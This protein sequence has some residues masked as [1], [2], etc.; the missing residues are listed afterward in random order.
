MYGNKA[1]LEEVFETEKLAEITAGSDVVLCEGGTTTLTASLNDW[2]ADELVFIWM[3]GEDSI[4]GAT[5]LTYTV[6][7]TLG[8]HHY[9]I[10]ILQQ[11]SGCVAES[12]EIVVNVNP[13]PVIASVSL[14]QT[15]I[16]YG[17]QV[18]VTAVPAEE[19]KAAG[20]FNLYSM[21]SDTP[22]WLGTAVSPYEG[23]L[24]TAASVLP[25]ELTH[26]VITDGVSVWDAEAAAQDRAAYGRRDSRD[27]AVLRRT[28]VCDIIRT[29]L[30]RSHRA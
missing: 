26:L 10:H 27:G 17:G 25:A 20:L 2:N 12:N 28:A 9:H 6:A 13:I 18:A 11:T 5:S 22:L 30:W 7:P 14:S 23:I 3:D 4:P 8:E 15:N 16:C 29:N 24:I 19:E 21:D 1:F